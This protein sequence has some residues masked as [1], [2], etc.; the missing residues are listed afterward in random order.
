MYHIRFLKFPQLVV[1]KESGKKGS[2]N[3]KATK[4]SGSKLLR[5][6]VTITNDL[7]E[8]F[9]F[10][11]VTLNIV[12]YHLD[13]RGQQVILSQKEVLWEPGFRSVIGEIEN[14][15]QLSR[16]TRFT[17]TI[18]QK[19]RK[20]SED[21]R[22]NFLLHKSSSLFVRIEAVNS[23]SAVDLLEED[24]ETELVETDSII[25]AGKCGLEFL[26]I[27][28]S[29]LSLDSEDNPDKK[30]AVRQLDLNTNHPN[31]TILGI[32][33]ETGE[34]IAKHLWDAG[35]YACRRMFTNKGSDFFTS[36]TAPR[37]ILELGT[38]C[39]TVGISLSIIFPQA[40]VTLTDL[41]D[42]KVVCERSIYVNRQLISPDSSDTSCDT[43][44]VH[45]EE[46][47]WSSPKVPFPKKAVSKTGKSKFSGV[48]TGCW[49]LIVVSDCTY[50]PDSYEILLSLLKRT[51]SAKTRILLAHK[52][53]HSRESQFFHMLTEYGFDV[54]D[55][56]YIPG[57]ADKI[58]VSILQKTNGKKV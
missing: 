35:I 55:N 26:S 22:G 52:Y 4:G 2:K 47:E 48:D 50:N 44:R 24:D 49:D 25:A 42:A 9:F 36:V 15:E 46:L 53:R 31:E 57:V 45:F 7:G 51:A 21:E 13:S 28:S 40:Q 18:A 43:S 27:I 10:G 56:L 38:G 6:V 11:K 1:P 19:R 3:T 30:Y 5:T 20:V 54:L 12:A 41:V 8:K 37:S 33:E 17:E 14:I 29:P 58:R 34:S 39:G 32:V 23:E 16:N